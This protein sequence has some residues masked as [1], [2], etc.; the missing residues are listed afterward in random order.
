MKKPRP[1]RV[2]KPEQAVPFDPIEFKMTLMFAMEAG[3]EPSPGFDPTRLKL[4]LKDTDGSSKTLQFADIPINRFGIAVLQRYGKDTK[5]YSSFMF[6]AFA[7]MDLVR[8]GELSSHYYRPAPKDDEASEIHDA[9]LELAASF[10]LSATGG[11]ERRAFLEALARASAQ[12]EK[13]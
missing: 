9:V 11:F 6:R 4:K 10:P 1:I 8:S 3:H 5:K 12:D 13:A 7:L 2:V